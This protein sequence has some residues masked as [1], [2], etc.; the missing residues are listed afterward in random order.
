MKKSSLVFGSLL[1]VVIVF[2]YGC[3]T[4]PVARCTTPGDTVQ[5]NF[6]AGM[7]AI[8]RND[9]STA[10]MRLQ[11]SIACDENYSPAYGGMAIVE[12][13]KT[14][15]QGEGPARAAGIEA[16]TKLLSKADRKARSEEDNFQ[17]YVTTIRVNTIVEGKGW[18]S[19]AEAA[20]RRADRMV[21]NEKN[22]PYYQGHEALDYFLGLA[23]MKSYEFQKAR[24][25]FG[26]VVKA[27]EGRWLGP[28]DGAW[29]KNDKIARALGGTALNDLARR[30]ALQDIVTREDLCGLLA[31]EAGIGAAMNR[32]QA[33]GGSTAPDF[34]PADIKESPFGTQ[35][36]TV[37]K[38]KVRGMEPVYDQTSKAYLFKPKE[39]V[40]RAAMAL[41][42][43]EI[44]MR[45]TGDEK[46]ATAFVGEEK[47]PFLDVKPT[48]PIFNAVMTATSRGMMEPDLSG[49]FRPGS[50]VN[51]AEAILAIRVLRG[52]TVSQ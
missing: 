39:K 12:A 2:L 41:V 25:A 28:A 37:L 11:R 42:L 29:K 18:L 10:E 21:V 26:R 24:D 23:Y 51:G 35:I 47:S 15:G 48:S 38:W 34:I 31:A 40:T 30:I 14:A 27:K 22:L 13:L 46:M 8:G 9:L 36:L 5:D 33:P 6:I 43:E 7:E 4:K 19:K 3:A 50:P 32:A 44:L 17:V 52:K 49:E 16:A 20:Y 45:V 1:V